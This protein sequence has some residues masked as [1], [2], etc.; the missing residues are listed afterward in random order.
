MFN[1][2]T[3]IQVR[4]KLTLLMLINAIEKPLTNQTITDVILDAGLINFIS[5]QHYLNELCE[6]SMLEQIP[7]EGK[8][9]YLLTENGRVALEFFKAR[10]PLHT[11]DK[12][13]D[14]AKNYKAKLPIETQVDCYYKRLDEEDYEVTLEISENNKSIMSIKLNVMNDKHAEQICSN[15]QDQA[16]HNYGHILN[17]LTKDSPT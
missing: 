5:M 12:I 1:N 9:Y 6:L 13:L 10:I 4:E 14:I 2:N 17:L 7:N 8:S 15:W 16:T 11:Q 3:D